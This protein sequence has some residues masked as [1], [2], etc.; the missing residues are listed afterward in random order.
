MSNSFRNRRL[1]RIKLDLSAMLDVLAC[2]VATF[3]VSSF[4]R[5]IRGRLQNA[6][7]WLNDES[8]DDRPGRNTILGEYFGTTSGHDVVRV[9]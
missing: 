3:F 7:S 8:R 6:P 2:T 4:E 5:A 9:S 1:T